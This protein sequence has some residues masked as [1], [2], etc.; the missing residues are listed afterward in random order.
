MKGSHV[1]IAVILLAL[2]LTLT[3]ALALALFSVKPLVTHLGDLTA[4]EVRQIEQL[5]ADNSPSRFES[6]GERELHLNAEE[7]N[8]LTAFLL[9]N[10]PPLR[11]MAASFHLQEDAGQAL[12][13]IPAT[14]GPVTLYLNLQA[15]FEQQLERARLTSLRA[16]SLRVPRRAIRLAEQLASRRFATAT[17]ASREIADLRH[18]VSATALNDGKL[19]LQ[20]RWAPES[21]SQLRSQAQQIFLG[22]DDRERILTYYAVISDIANTQIQERRVVSLHAFLPPLFE[23]ADQRSEQG[24]AMAENRNLLQVLSLY[25]N[26]LP[27]NQLID[28]APD[29]DWLSPPALIVTLQR[30]HD[31]S[32]HF[33]TAAAIAASAG[34]NIAEVLA[35]SK[36]VY[37]A[38]QRSG[39]SFSDMTANIAGVALGEASTRSETSARAIQKLLS[40][41]RYETDYMPVPSTDADGLS[42]EMLAEAFGD[43]TT[44][45]YLDKI[46][47]IEAK[48]A[49]LDIYQQREPAEIS[50]PES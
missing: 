48:V 42:E 8:L 10:V 3:A 44:E 5:I 45:N 24:N 15:E 36:E 29:D 39:F 33:I 27:L 35:H 20:L 49:A 34:A 21:L 38:R 46:S 23:L 40:K 41:A 19:H 31:L 14:L 22:P 17:N 18:N 50:P 7:L 13:S 9:A 2:L 1:N 25:V 6:Q 16:G 30:R 28:N 47:Q 43:R 4:A 11:G 32:L 26:G 12:L 37:D